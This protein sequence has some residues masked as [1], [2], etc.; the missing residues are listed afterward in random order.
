MSQVLFDY[1]DH[2]MELT[3]K[4]Q[5]AITNLYLVQRLPKNLFQIPGPT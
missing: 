5:Q 3:S 1:L 4:E 2:F